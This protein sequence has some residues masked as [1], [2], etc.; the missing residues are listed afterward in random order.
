M[1]RTA[2]R[3]VLFFFFSPLFSIFST[4]I[5]YVQRVGWAGGRIRV[6]G[7]VGRWV[8]RELHEGGKSVDILL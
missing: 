1:I 8:G 7:G 4:S 5:F 2:K 6:G 3:S